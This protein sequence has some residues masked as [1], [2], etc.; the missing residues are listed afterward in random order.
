MKHLQPFFNFQ[1]AKGIARYGA[2][3]VDTSIGT[4]NLAEFDDDKHR[5]RLLALFA[6]HP[7]TLV[8]QFLEIKKQGAM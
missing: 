5:S 4:F 1:Q 6:E 2:C 3:F 7:P 8:K